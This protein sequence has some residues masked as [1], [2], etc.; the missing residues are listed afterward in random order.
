M[1]LAGDLV[2][3][4]VAGA[5]AGSVGVDG[6]T[7]PSDGFAAGAARVAGDPS[8]AV[9]VCVDVHPVTSASPSATMLLSTIANEAIESRS[10]RS[11]EM[12]SKRPSDTDDDV[13]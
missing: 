4:A 8:L 12:T 9:G 7:M 10:A 11:I 6:V 5:I 2:G 13:T 1:E 3:E